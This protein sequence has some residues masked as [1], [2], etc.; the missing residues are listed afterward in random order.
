M[1][2]ERRDAPPALDGRGGQLDAAQLLE[3]RRHE[4]GGDGGSEAAAAQQLQRRLRRH[5]EIGVRDE[6]PLFL[7]M[8]L[9]MR[10]PA[11]LV[12]PHPLAQPRAH[13][14][15]VLRVAVRRHRP[16]Q[17]RIRHEHRAVVDSPPYHRR[18]RALHRT[19]RRP[20]RRPLGHRRLDESVQLFSRR[21]EGR[22]LAVHAVDRARR[23]PHRRQ[24]ANDAHAR[25]QVH[26]VLQRRHHRHH[27]QVAAV[28]RFAGGGEV[29]GVDGDERHWLLAKLH[30]LLLR[31]AG[32][33]SERQR[34][35]HGG[36]RHRRRKGGGSKGGRRNWRRGGGR[37]GGGRTGGRSAPSRLERGRVVVVHP[38][39]GRLRLPPPL[40]QRRGRRVRR[41]GR[42]CGG[43]ELDDRFQHRR[44]LV[45]RGGGQTARGCQLRLLAPRRRGA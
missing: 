27:R 7:R 29:G 13:R 17:A 38:P 6:R 28:A 21:G 30:L 14:L 25:E 12:P 23:P 5:C 40:G 24:H 42:R 34:R 41:G 37:R 4:E 31:L 43:A 18:Q 35:R 11:Q 1:E 8:R 36:R 19:V 26:K 44:H 22:R 33:R 32:R 9:A 45:W 15:L 39:A 3:V 2:D 20:L 10:Q 16:R